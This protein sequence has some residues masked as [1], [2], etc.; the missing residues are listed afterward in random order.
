MPLIL[1][2]VAGSDATAE[3]AERDA[4][5][6]APLPR[7]ALRLGDGGP[8]EDRPDTAEP[9]APIL[10]T[11]LR[12]GVV[13]EPVG[14]DPVPPADSPPV[15]LPLGQPE[16]GGRTASDEPVAAAP[17]PTPFPDADVAPQAPEPAVVTAAPAA[18][19][20]PVASAGP[21]R[22]TGA[23]EP[24]ARSADRPHLPAP[25]LPAPPEAWSFSVSGWAPAK[26][27]AP[28]PPRAPRPAPPRS[29]AA[30]AGRSASSTAAQPT[31][32]QPPVARPAPPASRP[33][34]ASSPPPPPPTP[35][36]TAPGTPPVTPGGGGS[37]GS[38][39]G[40]SG[41]GAGKQPLRLGDHLVDL[42]LISKDQ[43]Q[44]ALLEKRNSSKM[45][46]ELLVDLGFITEQALSAV[47][48]EAS[49]FERFEP[50]KAMVDAM[51]LKKLPKEA[52]LRYR[53]FPVDVDADGRVRVAMAD[54]YDVVALD[55]LK[56]YFGADAEIHPLVC[57]ETDIQ[58]AI[59][60]YYGHELSI[61]GI[62]RELERIGGEAEELAALD[63]DGNYSHP[64]VRLVDAIILDAVKQKASDIHFEPEG[65]F[66]RVRYRID[67][68]MTQIRTIHKRHWPAFSHRLKLMAGMN[69]ADKLNPQDGRIGMMLGNQ[70][71]DFR[72]S[73]LPTVS[74]ENLVLRILDK[75]SATVPIESLGYTPENFALLTRM[76][77]R[78]EGII[79]V[80]GPTG[81]G[82]TTTLYAVLNYIN[83]LQLNIMTLE[84]PVEYELSL[85]R[86]SQ[87][88]EG[89][90]MTFADGIR[91]LL[92]QDP[93][94][95]LVGE[96]R[97]SDTATMALRAAMTGHQVYT[98]LHTNDAA[99]A[100]PR[101]ID[102]GMRPSLM[103]GNIIGIVAQRLGRKLCNACKRPREATEEECRI[104]GFEPGQAAVIHEPVGCPECRGT[105]HKG[106][107]A[108]SEILPF[109]DTIDEMIIR[110]EPVSAI[111]REAMTIGFVPMIDDGVRK[112]LEGTLSIASLMRCVDVTRR[113]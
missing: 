39:S 61:D 19:A 76:I 42:G 15:R 94:V 7:V 16:E 82:K 111:R 32:A 43:L 27:S 84:D 30:P 56:R 20:V 108:I 4:P 73:S 44:V 107:I 36:G 72:V 50:G 2:P 92:R 53:V 109:S 88:R 17:E 12:L 75:S 38:G 6:T 81:S 51:L 28:A 29:P 63:A 112:V 10:P 71:I 98:T 89:T 78:P 103:A 11:S 101:L 57:G 25:D 35:T 26:A 110:D 31:A 55:Q 34:V 13:A 99:G 66:L 3:D 70:K 80:T 67:G 74:G 62:L 46:G 104:L 1:G 64:V 86:Q 90:Q 65:N 24:A 52:A 41:S 47:L 79:I 9:P 18:P 93:D 96:V 69:I 14:D 48:A 40:G 5:V 97:D 23:G 58:K 105:G 85:I 59:D 106:R 95:I 68:E 91:T 54:I 45:L 21:F 22:V 77:K 87:I 100:I 8:A 83:S 49:G 33:V 37:G 113:L 102:L 60:Q